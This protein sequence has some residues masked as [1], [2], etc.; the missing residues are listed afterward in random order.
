MFQNSKK[1]LI[2][3]G[4]IVKEDCLMAMSEIESLLNKSIWLKQD[5]DL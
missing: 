1:V 3:N 4:A 2:F 5:T